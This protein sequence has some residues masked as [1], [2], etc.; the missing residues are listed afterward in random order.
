M[1]KE[2]Q[3]QTFLI[4]ASITRLE[5]AIKQAN[6]VLSEQDQLWQRATDAI[7]AKAVQE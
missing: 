4:L 2:L 7:K 6:K 1:N 5:E 3:R